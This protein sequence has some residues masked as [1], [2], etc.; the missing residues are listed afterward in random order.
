[1]K[2]YLAIEKE[3]VDKLFKKIMDY[4]VG[5]TLFIDLSQEEATMLAVFM[6]AVE[7]TE[8]E[9]IEKDSKVFKVEL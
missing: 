6:L 1:M 9:N 5:E 7:K 8:P 3:K 4:S 2:R